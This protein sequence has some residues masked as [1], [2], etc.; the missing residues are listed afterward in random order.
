MSEKQTGFDEIERELLEAWAEGRL[1]DVGASLTLRHPLYANEIVAMS[2]ALAQED[3]LLDM[4]SEAFAPTLAELRTR[5]GASQRRVA[6]DLNIPTLVIDRLETVGKIFGVHPLLVT[7][8]AET[9]KAPR[10]E[11]A[12]ALRTQ[13]PQESFAMSYSTV[14]GQ[15]PTLGSGAPLASTE[16]H[17]FADLL[18]EAGVPEDDW[19]GLYDPGAGVRDV[20]A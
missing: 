11:V 2:L 1:E 3:L 19:E 18:R 10:Q 8:L 15:M 17:D 16:E 20:V 5:S 9:I 7:R 14:G 4:A 13:M 6:R 12:V